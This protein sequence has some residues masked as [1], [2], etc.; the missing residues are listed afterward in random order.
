MNSRYNQ[1]LPSDKIA[2]FRGTNIAEKEKC[3]ILRTPRIQ[4]VRDTV[5]QFVR[6]LTS[7]SLSLLPLS[8]SPSRRHP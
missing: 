6:L 3:V 8:S 2:I 4:G 7:L 5:P 1:I